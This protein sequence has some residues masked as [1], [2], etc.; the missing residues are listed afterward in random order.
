MKGLG[1]Y[2]KE[3]GEYQ[4]EQQKANSLQIDNMVKWNKALRASQR[5]KRLDQSR[6]DAKDRVLGDFDRKML[7]IKNGAA[8][9]DTI[10]RIVEFPAEG[11]RDALASTPLSPEALRALTFENDTE[12]LSLC[13]DE[14]TK[15]EGWPLLL[16]G[17]E[18]ADARAKLSAAVDAALKEDLSGTLA[19]DTRKGLEEAL[20]AFRK[21]LDEKVPFFNAEKND[22]QQY[23]IRLTAM[24]KM[25][26]DPDTSPIVRLLETYKQGTLF[27][28]VAFMHAFNLKVGPSADERQFAIYKDLAEALDKVPTAYDDSK[29]AD[30]S[31][32]EVATKD[33]ANASKDVFKSLEWADLDQIGEKPAAAPASEK[34]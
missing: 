18:F 3:K 17:D 24:A 28:L 5:L 27:D 9:N 6:Q 34:K 21:T 29:L 30:P 19:D 8:L 33:L 15:E 4:I 22:A 14:L 20:A 11:T 12:A 26:E 1:Y 32:I 10:D 13:L 7:R 31:Q 25:L 16:K 23:L 2:L